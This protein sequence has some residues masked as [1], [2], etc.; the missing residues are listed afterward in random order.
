MEKCYLLKLMQA[1][2]E[3]CEREWWRGESK[4]DIF[5]IL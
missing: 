4:Y 2:G 5:G 1:G 3:D